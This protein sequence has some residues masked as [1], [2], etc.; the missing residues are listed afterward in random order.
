MVFEHHSIRD[1]VRLAM[2]FAWR[3]ALLRIIAAALCPSFKMRYPVEWMADENFNH[4]LHLVGR[5]GFK[6]VNAGRHWMLMQLLRLTSNVPGD[7]AECGVLHGATSYLIASSTEGAGKTHHLF[8]SF[9]GLSP[10]DAG[11]GSLWRGN[12]L[13][14]DAG[15]AKQLL[16]RFDNVAFHEG[17]IPSRF[18]DVEDRQFSFVHI[19]VDLYQP[20]HD[21]IVFFYSRLSPG[22]VVVCDDYGFTTCPGATRAFD[23]FLSDKP[24]KMLALSDGGGFFIKG[25]RTG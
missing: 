16:S 20:T 14:S 19:D 23:E 1:R 24:E 4:Y 12:D 10:P 15:H 3:F 6:S 7:T 8:D 13:A 25:T 9:Q 17:W 21:S 2:V 18:S 5:T 11:D 22:A